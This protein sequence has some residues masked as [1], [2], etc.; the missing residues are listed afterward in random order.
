M[1]NQSS[2][3]IICY[4]LT[5]TKRITYDATHTGPHNAYPASPVTGF[6][7]ILSIKTTASTP[8]G[9]SSAAMAT[10]HAISFRIYS[11]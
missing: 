5:N 10:Q 3:H 11:P 6:V 1:I 2:R 7:L 9:I 8:L 4:K